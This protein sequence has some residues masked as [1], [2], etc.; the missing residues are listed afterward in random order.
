M[1][2]FEPFVRSSGITLWAMVPSLYGVS[3]LCAL[4]FVYLVHSF[5]PGLKPLLRNL[6]RLKGTGWISIVAAIGS[7]LS[8]LAIVHYRGIWVEGIGFLI[9]IAGVSLM[10]FMNIDYF[11]KMLEDDDPDPKL[12]TLPRNPEQRSIEEDIARSYSWLHKGQQYHLD[13]VIRKSLYDLCKSKAR[14]AS[15]EWAREYASEGIC[16]EIREIAFRLQRMG[17]PYGSYEEV[18]FV[19]SFVQQIITYQS[20]E[21]EYPKYPV[22]T[23]V[24]AA[25]DCEDFSILGASILKLMGY[26]VALLFLPGHAALGVAGAEGIPGVFA[27]HKGNKFYYCEMTSAGWKIGEL[28][29]QHKNDKIDV[30]PVPGVVLKMDQ[31]VNT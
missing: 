29:E 25:G 23:L 14:V 6:T 19:L 31:S 20:D 8:V 13:L 17:K 22:E 30:Y 12:V 10:N 16:G 3:F 26:E 1:R 11:P 9:P 24:D 27:E 28:P 7:G 15:T 2:L 5:N 18:D 21:G 4:L